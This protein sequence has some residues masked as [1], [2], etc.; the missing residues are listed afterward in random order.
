M[1]VIFFLP[2]VL[3][4]DE[5]D[6]G[7]VRLL[8]YC[9]GKKPGSIGGATQADIDQV[10]G[11]Y[12]DHGRQPTSSLG[13]PVANAT[14]VHWV[15]D[16]ENST[17]SQVEISKRMKF[18]QWLILAG[19]S[20]RRYG[21]HMRYCNS[22]GLTL[23]GQHYANGQAGAVSFDTRR[24]D[25]VS[26]RVL[27]ATYGRPY[28]LRPIN[29]SDPLV[30]EFD[31]PLLKALMNINDVDL[32]NRI[33]DS[34]VMFNRANTDA[35]EVPD[36]AEM[37]MLRAAFE[38]LLEASHVKSDL[39][40]KFSKHFDSLPNLAVWHNGIFDEKAWRSRWEDTNAIKRPLDAWINDFCNARN[41]SAHGSASGSKYP[42]SI[43]SMRN[44]LMFA[45]WLFPLMVKGVI[46]E[47]G[48]YTLSDED[49]DYRSDFEQFFAEDIS[50]P[51]NGST[52]PWNVV[53]DTIGEKDLDRSV[54]AAM[55]NYPEVNTLPAR[56]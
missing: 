1:S 31:I 52:L 50:Q 54:R 17:I 14:I 11:N 37:V 4:K 44:H 25:G 16:G 51:I 38:T 48:I 10:L 35:S 55:L 19:L 45:S 21:S 8:P 23:M 39:V 26:K 36:H 43:W 24:R 34:V 5:L 20:E 12:A 49:K 13:T 7:S 29:V 28:F 30:V 22:D 2:W 47:H 15:T 32:E 42:P 56:E 27:S 41:S 3:T 18:G 46:A 33:Y 9:R 40:E 6:I 53:V